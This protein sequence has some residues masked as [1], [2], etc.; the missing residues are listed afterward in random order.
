MIVFIGHQENNTNMAEISIPDYLYNLELSIQNDL[1]RQIDNI[2]YT[3]SD[4]DATI[5]RLLGSIQI[6]GKRQEL[7]IKKLTE[8]KSIPAEQIKQ[9][10]IEEFKSVL[11]SPHIES[12]RLAPRGIFFIKTK[13]LY[14]KLPEW[15][16]K[17]KL[18]QF[19]ICF[20]LT[21][22]SSVQILN[23]THAH[24]NNYDSPVV[25]GTEPC[26]GSMG[27]EIT[28][29]IKDKNI[30]AIIGDLISFL[31]SPDIH[32]GYIS[33]WADFFSDMVKR[34]KFYS[35]NRRAQD[36][37]IKSMLYNCILDRNG[38]YILGP[39]HRSA[40]KKLETD[41]SQSNTILNI[42]LSRGMDQIAVAFSIEPTIHQSFVRLLNGSTQTCRLFIVLIRLG[43]T[44]TG[45]FIFSQLLCSNNCNHDDFFALK[46]INKT[47]EPITLTARDE[48]T[49]D[50]DKDFLIPDALAL[51]RQKRTLICSYGSAHASRKPTRSVRTNFN[52]YKL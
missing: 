51:I 9:K 16:R 13:M 46:C 17:R 3:I 24:N 41:I 42:D 21:D 15:K 34:P 36:R 29:D 37:K 11:E 8:M 26:W 50:I 48:L 38:I 45:A 52:F 2:K 44:Y 39:N 7:F 30:V 27:P 28:Q 14:V 25:N 12:V 31:I 20:T 32:S 19:E 23:I 33:D 4:Y 22:R 6:E 40:I 5:K 10:C 49:F 35:L 18:G 1:Q 47:Q 43:F